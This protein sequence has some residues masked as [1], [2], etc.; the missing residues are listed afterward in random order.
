MKIFYMP[1]FGICGKAGI[2]PGHT[3]GGEPSRPPGAGRGVAL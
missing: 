3:A 1:M 2:R